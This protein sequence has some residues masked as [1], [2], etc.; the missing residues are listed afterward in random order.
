MHVLV[1]L[2]NIFQ[3]EFIA[4][5]SC[6]RREERCPRKHTQ[7]N[8]RIP[9]Q[10]PSENHAVLAER[11]ATANEP[12]AA[13]RRRPRRAQTKPSKKAAPAAPTNSRRIVP[14]RTT[15]W[16]HCCRGISPKRSCQ[17][18][19]C[20]QKKVASLRG[21]VGEDSVALRDR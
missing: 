3:A 12:L 10:T 2:I 11:P 19:V 8:A 6:C 16:C 15:K 9:E 14:Y 17:L 13:R 18:M 21:N 4:E 1:K 5:P 20:Q 7:N